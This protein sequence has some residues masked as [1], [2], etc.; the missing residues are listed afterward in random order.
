MVRS[1]TQRA[2]EMGCDIHGRRNPNRIAPE[3]ALEGVELRPPAFNDLG[4]TPQD[5]TL[6]RRARRGPLRAGDAFAAG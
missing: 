4:C 6:E 5:A 2:I 1:M 3:K